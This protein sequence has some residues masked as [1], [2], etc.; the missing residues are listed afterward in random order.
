MRLFPGRPDAAPETEQLVHLDESPLMTRDIARDLRRLAD[1][2]DERG[3]LQA[4]CDRIAE[5]AARDRARVSAGY[6]RGDYTLEQA[7]EATT[8]IA[9][10]AAKATR[11]QT[12][13]LDAIAGLRDEGASKVRARADEL[14]AAL[15]VEKADATEEVAQKRA[16]LDAAERR[17]A[18]VVGREREL[19]DDARRLLAEFDQSARAALLAQERNDADLVRWAVTQGASPEALAQLPERLRERAAEEYERAVLVVQLAN[20]GLA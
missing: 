15:A 10:A 3:E 6:Q 5:Q 11:R 19:N 4:E 9:A 8:A 16:E 17:Y 13:V 18:Q 2:E 14:R 1:A 12:I 7:E 20:A